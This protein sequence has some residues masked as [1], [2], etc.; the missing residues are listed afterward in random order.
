MNFKDKVRAE[1]EKML[2]L[3]IIRHSTSPYLNPVTVVSKCDNSVCLCLDAHD[4]EKNRR[5]KKNY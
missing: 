2:K 1:V 5:E 3:N 4:Y